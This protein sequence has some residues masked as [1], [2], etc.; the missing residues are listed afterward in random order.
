QILFNEN[1]WINSTTTFSIPMTINPTEVS[2]IYNENVLV[3]L[4]SVDIESLKAN[5]ENPV[6]VFIIIVIII[7]CSVPVGLLIIFKILRK[8][9]KILMEN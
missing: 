8:R 3:Q 6:I 9:K 1:V 2:L 7:A 5:V 4:S